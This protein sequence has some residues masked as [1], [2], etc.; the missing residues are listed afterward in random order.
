MNS[1]LENR[2]C[3]CIFFAI[4]FLSYSLVSQYLVNSIMLTHSVDSV[5]NRR[6]EKLPRRT[7]FPAFVR[8]LEL[9]ASEMTQDAGHDDRAIAPLLE[10]EVKFI[11]LDILIS[12][13]GT[14]SPQ[15]ALSKARTRV[16]TNSLDSATTEMLSHSFRYRRFLSNA[17]NSVRR[18]AV[19][20]ELGF[21]L[22][23]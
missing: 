11:V 2:A 9:K 20:A 5:E 12:W 4:L 13:Y 18:H 3:C 7:G 1:I 23:A 19:S 8:R 14:L 15:S 16:S 10:V 6:F 21:S 17:E 22:W